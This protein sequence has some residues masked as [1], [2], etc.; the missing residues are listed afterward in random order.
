MLLKC[1][2]LQHFRR[3]GG[4]KGERLCVC[5]SGVDE[6]APL[7][8]GTYERWDFESSLRGVQQATKL[9]TRRFSRQVVQSRVSWGFFLG[10]I[11]LLPHHNRVAVGGWGFGF[12]VPF[13]S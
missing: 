6:M 5:G 1:C 10:M 11:E 2:F 3:G 9:R 4:R 7:S 8:F 13:V 12:S